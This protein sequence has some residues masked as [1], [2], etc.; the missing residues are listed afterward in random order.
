MML[1]AKRALMGW[2]FIQNRRAHYPTRRNFRKKVQKVRLGQ[3][4]N[5]G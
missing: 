5:R 3:A 2:K 1:E 4:V